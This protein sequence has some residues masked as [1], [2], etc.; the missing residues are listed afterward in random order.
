MCLSHETSGL[1]N[2]KNSNCYLLVPAIILHVVSG[3]QDVVLFF[4]FISLS[5][6]FTTLVFFFYFIT[7]FSYVLLKFLVVFYY[8]IYYHFLFREMGMGR[9]LFLC[10]LCYPLLLSL[11]EQNSYLNSLVRTSCYVSVWT[12]LV[13]LNAAPFFHAIKSDTHSFIHAVC[14]A[15]GTNSLS[16][17]YVCHSFS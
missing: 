8:T 5:F 12:S 3:F 7:S 2:G 13:F 1:P 15:L 6:F 4:L 16:E 11:I 10:Y 14:C 17:S 9:C